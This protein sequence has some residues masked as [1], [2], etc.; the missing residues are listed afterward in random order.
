MTSG[1]LRRRR[2]GAQKAVLSAI[3]AWAVVVSAVA[4]GLIAYLAAATLTGVQDAVRTAPAAERTTQISTRLMADDTAG[5]DTTLRGTAQR[6]VPD[7]ELLVTRSLTTDP[8][9]LET[10][11]TSGR[12]VL[13][14][15]E[16]IED[17]AELTAGRWPADESTTETALHAVAAESLGLAIG[18]AVTVGDR[19]LTVAGTWLPAD[20]A[21]PFWFGEPLETTGIDG[22]AYGP[23]VVTEATLTSDGSVPLAR[24]RIS[25]DAAAL[26][27]ADLP[28]LSQGLARAASG[29]DGDESFDVR[30]VVVT[31][32]LAD[33]AA[34]LA[35]DVSRARSISLVPLIVLVAVSL[36]AGVQ[37]ARL[38]AAVRQ[39]ET[40]LYRSRGA[41]SGQLLRWSAIES[42]L[43][44]VPAAA[45]GAALAALALRLGLDADLEPV[46]IVASAAVVAIVAVGV[47]VVVA[48]QAVRRRVEESVAVASRRA[49]GAIGWSLT[50]GALI[51]AAVTIWQLRQYGSGAA[52]GGADLL[53]T[54][55]PALALL[56]LAAL[57]LAVLPVPLAMV[58]RRLAGRRRLGALLP[59]WEMSRR[60]PSYA[61][62]VVLVAV[63]TGAG[64]L[65][66]SYSG[67]W[68]GLQDDL[69][70]SRTGSDVRAVVEQRGP[71][72]TGRPPTPV[73]RY[74]DIDGVDT[75]LP[76]NAVSARIGDVA[77]TTLAI[78]A[79]AAES[80][81]TV[82]TDLFPVDGLASRLVPES[83]PASIVLP[84]DTRAIEATVE[85][86]AL[87]L[88]LADSDGA[89]AYVDAADGSAEVPDG[90]T[91]ASVSA[92]QL[93]A[94]PGP[95]TDTPVVTALVAV[96][97][98]GTRTDIDLAATTDWGVITGDDILGPEPLSLAAPLMADSAD[99][100]LAPAL[101][102]DSPVAAVLSRSLLGATGLVV[103]DTFTAQLFG[104][105][106][107]MMV[108][109][110]ADVV[111]GVD[112]PV[113]MVV[114]LNAV[115]TA[116]VI[117]AAGWP[118]GVN[119][120]WMSAS[121][122]AAAAAAVRAADLGAA[123]V[124]D[125]Q[126]ARDALVGQG[127]ARQAVFAFWA[128]AVAA[129]VL[130]AIGA[131]A[132]TA[133]STRQ[134]R[135]EL[136][137]L[138]VVGVGSAEQARAWRTEQIGMSGIALVVGAIGGVALA[139][140][141]AG[142]LALGATSGVP[143]ALDPV[144]RWSAPMLGG[145]VAAL[146]VTVV[147]VAWF[148]A[149]RVGRE[150]SAALPGSERR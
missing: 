20:E 37:V 135:G 4:T 130:T 27:P 114:D 120:V 90:F 9:G 13:M 138:R 15:F 34:S 124:V 8:V 100:R 115:N 40:T 116:V 64:I 22:S 69:A 145:F 2:S 14:A 68:T 89:L 125:R 65:A 94:S 3:A 75:A 83:Q 45:V 33:T 1:Y 139:A 57:A 105:Q 23:F 48:A 149:S 61:A 30:G 110:E 142:V 73:D 42:V 93:K 107:D 6:A 129:I 108:A 49:T 19:D 56:G 67:T 104:A 66:A 111:P 117:G 70:A 55:G 136:A 144:E 80:V 38:L 28:G 109:D 24:W 103:G 60:L 84:E 53:A 112:D 133:T 92:V 26:T 72:N 122:P 29:L 10:A 126:T 71:L 54:P 35:D 62:V 39:D 134:R 127:L 137:V 88:I 43:V 44:A 121:S 5:Q 50:L 74:G 36:V 52:A 147:A 59:A 79:A 106:I 41:T 11:E 77:L 118:Q 12:G 143:G 86:A 17:H 131:M 76:A 91:A 21:D 18:D 31:T 102:A 146:V 113:A 81:L 46:P 128:V 98:A 148:Y 47:L 101:P 96:D 99:V 87:E 97:S 140:L 7:V 150:A 16:S 25:A 141:A 85:G 58:E 95:V 123:Q 119:Q 63:T 78:P 32:G 132:S 82:R 51:A